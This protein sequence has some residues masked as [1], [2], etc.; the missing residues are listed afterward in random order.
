MI[1]NK[2]NA[3]NALKVLYIKSSMEKLNA[4][5]IIE[6]VVKIKKVL[7]KHFKNKLKL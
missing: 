1:R 5:L 3:T 2:G 7:L 6:I 4:L